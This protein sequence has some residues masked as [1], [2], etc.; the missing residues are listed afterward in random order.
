MIIPIDKE[1]IPYQFEIELAGNV[2]VF[3]INHNVEHNFFTFDLFKD[4]EVLAL[5]EKLVYGSPLF[6]Y[7]DERFPEVTITPKDKSGNET[8]V[9][10]DNFGETVFLF[11]GDDDAV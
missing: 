2:F 10:Y 11:V 6:S 1:N 9:T 5:G 7:A 8:R 4:D 3:E